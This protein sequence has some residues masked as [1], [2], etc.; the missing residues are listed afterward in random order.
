MSTGASSGGTEA[1]PATAP[2]PRVRPQRRR[3]RRRVL[4]VA[5]C[6]AAGLIV[7]AGAGVFLMSHRADARPPARTSFCGL[8]ACAVLHSDAETTSLPTVS[9]APR[10]APSPST[11]ASSRAPAVAPAVAPAP[12]PAPGPPSVPAA[13]PTSRPAA[14]GSGPDVV[15]GAAPVAAPTAAPARF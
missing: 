15:T 13:S 9:P 1:P 6:A 7:L 10:P 4:P 2:L 12:Q 8:V 14:H 5:A 11:V 3:L